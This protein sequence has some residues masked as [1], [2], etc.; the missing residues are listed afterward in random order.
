MRPGF[1]GGL[2]A[3]FLAGTLITVILGPSS[4]LRAGKKLYRISRG[5]KKKG[6][7]L[8]KRVGEKE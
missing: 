2:F 1:F 3:G 8:I 7:L 4:A 6:T 5:L